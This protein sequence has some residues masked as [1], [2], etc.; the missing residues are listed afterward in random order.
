[1]RSTCDNN[2]HATC[3]ELG[4]LPLVEGGGAK[5]SPLG[6]GVGLPQRGEIGGV[7]GIVDKKMGFSHFEKVK[8]EKQILSRWSPIVWNMGN[9]KKKFPALYLKPR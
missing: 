6:S 8:N 4:A 1:M 9:P 5:H 3:I 7:T 2:R